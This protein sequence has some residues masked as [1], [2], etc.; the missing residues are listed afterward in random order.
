M[1][2]KNRMG[3]GATV[4]ISIAV[5]LIVCGS[6]LLLRAKNLGQ[7]LRTAAGLGGAVLLVLGV[8]LAYCLLSGRI[9]L[10]LW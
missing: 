2:P 10:P 8:L 3:G 1:I 7:G 9:V 5:L 6:L 4:L